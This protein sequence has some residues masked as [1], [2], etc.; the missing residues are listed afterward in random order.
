[1]KKYII[2]ISWSYSPGNILW[3][4]QITI[5]F[6]ANH[7]CNS[8]L[9]EHQMPPKRKYQHQHHIFSHFANW[10][11]DNWATALWFFI[12]MRIFLELVLW[13]WISWMLWIFY[14]SSPKQQGQK[15]SQHEVWSNQIKKSFLPKRLGCPCPVPAPQSPMMGWKNKFCFSMRQASGTWDAFPNFQ[16]IFLTF[17]PEFP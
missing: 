13:I 6:L 8:S 15:I 10:S 1:M 3:V 9:P 11:A 17:K 12:R 5:N 16:H 14:Y 4:H 7:R 2:N